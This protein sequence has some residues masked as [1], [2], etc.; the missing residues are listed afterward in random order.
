MDN[1][2]VIVI[3][4]CATVW[5]SYLI[6]EV[7]EKVGKL[8]ALHDLSKEDAAVLAATQ[9]VKD[10]RSKIPPPETANQKGK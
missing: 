4:I 7:G 1:V 2:D 5:L 9:N 3:I 6:G 8:L 10:A